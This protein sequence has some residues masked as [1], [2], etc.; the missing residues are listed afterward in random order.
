MRRPP[1][2]L[3]RDRRRQEVPGRIVDVGPVPIEPALRDALDASPRR[4]VGVQ[5]VGVADEVADH[6]VLG[7]HAEPA[8]GI[9]GPRRDS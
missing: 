4:R 6:G 2:L 8:F 9:S 1:A 5:E 7:K 3:G